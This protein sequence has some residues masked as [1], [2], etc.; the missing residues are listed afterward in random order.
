[1]A[2]KLQKNHYEN[3]K[4]ENQSHLRK[5]IKKY[6]PNGEAVD[7]LQGYFFY[8]N[9]DNDSI[10]KGTRE[11]E[12]PH[13]P[14]HKENFDLLKVQKRLKRD[15][16]F[17][18][19][20]E[21]KIA[22]DILGSEYK[23]HLMP[24]PEYVLDCLDKL[25]ETINKNPE[26]KNLIETFKVCTTLNEDKPNLNKKGQIM[27]TIVIYPKLGKTA[28]EKL[29]QTI[30]KI[31][32]EYDVEE[33]GSGHT[34]RF[35]SKKNNLVY[36][37]QGGGDLKNEWIRE[38]PKEKHDQFLTERGI[39]YAFS[40][41]PALTIHPEASNSTPLPNSLCIGVSQNKKNANQNKKSPSHSVVWEK[42]T[43]D[44]DKPTNLSDVYKEISAILNE[45][46]IKFL[47]RLY[48]QNLTPYQ[49]LG[50]DIYFNQSK[51][52]FNENFKK[53]S[54][55]IKE[56]L[57]AGVAIEPDVKKAYQLMSHFA[58]KSAVDD[59]LSYKKLKNFTKRK[60]SSSNFNPTQS[61]SSTVKDSKKNP[62]M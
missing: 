41:D 4:A 2:K 59:F 9:K 22:E 8:I 55:K 10:L 52:S 12:A 6:D 25:L 15:W 54:E 39:H 50:S 1:M 48:R 45:E 35:N 30:N 43:Q 24:K 31:F 28:A 23:I 56:R 3:N 58:K 20:T 13:T 34:P 5:I 57:E 60:Q 19:T 38:L 53:I 44:L 18:N 7:M 42:V 36:Y 16:M 37:C 33:I 11:I 49:L 17:G 46:E 26:L 51:K 21:K 27:P 14:Y 32:S 62:E 47:E 61:M 29:L 40:S